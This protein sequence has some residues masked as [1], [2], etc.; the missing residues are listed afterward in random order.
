MTRRRLVPVP[1]PAASPAAR[2]AAGGPGDGTIDIFARTLW[3]E[4]RTETLR[5]MEAVAAVVMNRAALEPGAAIA[6]ICRRFPCWSAD[7]PA[8]FRLSVVQPSGPTGSGRAS[9]DALLFATCLRIA[10][11]AAAGLLDDPTGGA[12]LYH[13]GGI[14]PDWA[15]RLAPTA[16]IGDRLFYAAGGGVPS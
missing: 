11:R 1:S 2:P 3:G 10:R 7:N 4:A 15:A 13:D 12:T 14:L 5:G 8:L 9:S 6:D 16:E